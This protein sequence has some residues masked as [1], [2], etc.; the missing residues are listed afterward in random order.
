MSFVLV[1]P[2]I[3]ETVA[4]DVAQIGAAVRA[5]NLAAAIPTTELAAA[6][7]DEV[8]AAI[9]ALFGAHAHE[10]Q[11]VAAQAAAYHEQFMHKLSGA[12]ASYAGAEATIAAS[13]G[14]A[15]SH[16][17]QTFV[18]APVHTAGEAWIN[19]PTGQLL[20][21]AVN[22][23]TNMLFGRDLIG[24]G[25]AGT[26]AAPNGRP[27]GLLFGDGGPGY[28]PTG[29]GTVAGGNGGNAGFIGNGGTGGGGINGGAGGSGGT[30]GGLMGNGGTGGAGDGAG[31][32]GAGGQALLFG[33][34]GLGGAGGTGGAVGRG[35]LF[36]G[37]GGPGP[38]ATTTGGSGQQIVIDFVRHGETASN[39]AGLIDTAVPGPHLD[40][41]GQAQASAIA[42]ELQGNGPYAG[43][44]ESQLLRTQDTAAPLLT[45][46]P[47]TTAEV[48]PGLNEINAGALEGMQQVP[49][50]LLYL[51]GPLAWTLGFPTVPMLAPGSTHFNGVVFD[52]GFEGAMQT[53]YSA[54]MANPVVSPDG[55]ITTVAYSSALAIEVGTLM[56]VNNPDPLLMLTHTLPNTGVVV[57]QGD[58]QGGWTMV[59]WDGEPVPPASL[60]TKLF[61]DVRDLVTAPQFAGFD[62]GQALRTG[63][64]ATIV[65]AIHDGANEVG[66]AVVEFP[67]AVAEDLLDAV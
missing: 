44:F 49:G 45:A 58:P 12:A 34:G 32:G 33:N 31:S 19:S 29:M 50:G 15:V 7:G 56:N 24:N 4:A 39:A 14:S 47:G 37:E 65:N 10:Y 16:G 3:L 51:V 43:I 35:G 53:M 55:N 57:V 22:A 5:G 9:A 30:G 66:A 13:L 27:G 40:A 41:V 11:V 67:H 48:L 42:N 1:A 23:P 63:D 8:S 20:D 36:L 52:R 38:S 25:I 18:Y 46:F 6:G 21:P 60:G 62:I 61:V 26:A 59:S 2:E 17:F 64:P 28:T 54:A